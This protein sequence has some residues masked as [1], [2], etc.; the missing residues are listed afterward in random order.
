MLITVFMNIRF[1]EILKEPPREL[2][3]TNHSADSAT[4]G[5]RFQR[6]IWIERLVT[7]S[8]RT[9]DSINNWITSLLRITSLFRMSCLLNRVNRA[10]TFI[11]RV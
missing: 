10:P 1:L 5:E 3:S 11:C 6:F 9:I 2:R 4:V 8:I 7:K